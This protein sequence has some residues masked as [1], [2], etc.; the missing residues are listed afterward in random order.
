MRRRLTRDIQFFSR[1]KLC[2]CNEPSPLRK[3]HQRG[4]GTSS[5]QTL[6]PYLWGFTAKHGHFLQA[7]V[8]SNRT[9]ISGELCLLCAQ[10]WRIENLELVPVEHQWY[11]FFY[12]GDCYLVLYTYEVYGK[13]HYILYIWQV[14][15]EQALSFER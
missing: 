5:R 12:G 14:G 6:V 2:K 4:K 13:L 1:F 3:Q 10:V 11:G 15:L 9:P 7:T 8:S